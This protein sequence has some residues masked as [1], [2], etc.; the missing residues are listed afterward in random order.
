MILG[1]AHN[2]VKRIDVQSQ[3][4]LIIGAGAIGLL[5]AS[6]AKAMGATTVMIADINSQRLELAK[7]MG[8]DI[9][10]NCKEVDLY[11]EVMKL[12]NN[13]GVPR[14]VEASGASPLVNSC[15]K[16]LQKVHL[17]AL[18]LFFAFKNRLLF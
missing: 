10:I 7:K 17:L 9:T 16:L 2:G 3:K 11:Q 4:V 1:V 13:D 6:I 12:T 15:F 14:L 18:I 8:A 5:A